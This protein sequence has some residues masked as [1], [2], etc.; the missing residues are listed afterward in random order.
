MNNKIKEVNN[1]GQS[2]WL[3]NIQRKQLKNGDLKT[4]IDNEVIQGITSNPSIFNNAISKTNEYD[5]DIRL[6]K[7][8]GLSGEEIFWELAVKDIQDASDL[9]RQYYQES[10]GMD[11]FVS[12]EVNPRLSKDSKATV[13]N[14]RNLWER[15]DR[16][17][18]MIKIP[19]TR[20]CL[21]AI[22]ASIAAGINVNATLIFSIERYREVVQ[23]FIDGLIQR[24]RSGSPISDIASV[25]SFFISRMDNK[26]DPLLPENS[27]LKGKA[28]IANARL[29]YR[30]FKV[31]FSN[32]SFQNMRKKGGQYQRPL[33]ASTSTK[34][35]NYSDTLYV[36]QLIGPQTVNTV[37]PFTLD[38]FR[39]H[40]VPALT[41]N[42]DLEDAENTIKD[43][44]ELGISFSVITSELEEEGVQAFIDAYTG[45]KRSIGR[46]MQ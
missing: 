17:N 35:D 12:L 40:G 16:P 43:L 15:V 28:A 23:A 29:A 39:D 22:T 24:V 8:K 1:L 41:I 9:F 34:N 45:L 18:L 5:E 2:I 6:L 33:W 46:K 7:S 42:R 3:D 13:E 25:A 31:L 30:D 37:P 20:E 21:P 44:G 27:N 4:L 26:V 36:D 38:A 11:G 19:A 14:A 10:S 32:D